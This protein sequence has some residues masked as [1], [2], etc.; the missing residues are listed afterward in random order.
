[1]HGARE[2]VMREGEVESRESLLQWM[3]RL[4]VGVHDL[5]AGGDALA[6]LFLLEE[7]LDV[8]ELQ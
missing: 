1:M 5:A 6:E 4:S 8:A 7:R 3:R 2:L